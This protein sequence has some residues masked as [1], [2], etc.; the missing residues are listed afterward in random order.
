MK[1]ELSLPNSGKF[2]HPELFAELARL[3]ASSSVSNRSGRSSM[4]SYAVP[5]CPIRVRK[6]DRCQAATTFLFP[7]RRFRL[8]YAAA[9]TTKL[10]LSHRRNHFAP[11]SS[12]LPGQAISDSRR[13]FE[14]PHDG[15]NR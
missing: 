10:K 3:I 13:T 14:G 6:T 9:L 5:I 1:S 12:A 7:I 8:A 15:W 2:S 11:A 4:L